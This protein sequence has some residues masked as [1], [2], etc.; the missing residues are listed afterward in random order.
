MRPLL[1]EQIAQQAGGAIVRRRVWLCLQCLER[2]LRTA[3]EAVRIV[4]GYVRRHIKKQARPGDRPANQLS[5]AQQL[6]EMPRNRIGPNEVALE[7]G[8]EPITSHE[9]HRSL[10]LEQRKVRREKMRPRPIPY[11]QATEDNLRGSAGR[12]DFLIV[13][14]AHGG[15]E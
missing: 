1:R 7:A 10:Q 15:G 5:T 12:T 9:A 11:A 14:I 4:Q 3:P 8:E 6:S 13:R 2:W